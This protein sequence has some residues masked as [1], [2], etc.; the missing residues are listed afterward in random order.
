MNQ[1]HNFAHNFKGIKEKILK[2]IAVVSRQ[3]HVFEKVG[4]SKLSDAFIRGFQIEIK[5]LEGLLPECDV[6]KEVYRINLDMGKDTR[7]FNLYFK[8]KE[9][10]EQ[11]VSFIRRTLTEEAK[12]K[13][14]ITG[15][16]EQVLS[17]KDA[18]KQLMQVFNVSEDEMELAR[19]KAK[20]KKKKT[21]ND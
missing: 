11:M 14:V 4:S 3:K 17:V 7:Q 5:F 15:T 20:K 12:E 8:D 19:K 6:P 13:I 21:F 2:R 18:V 1:T 16:A 10:A 9:T